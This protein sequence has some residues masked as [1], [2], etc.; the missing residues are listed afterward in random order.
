MKE[1]IKPARLQK[2]D[3]VAAISLSGGRAGDED[4]RWRYELGKKRLEEVFGLQVVETPHALRGSAYL[5]RNPQARAEDLHWALENRAVKG[6]IANMGGDDSYRLL[7]FLDERLIGENPKLLMGYSDITTTC[8][9][10][11]RAGV[12]SYYGPNLLTPIAQ[13]GSLD[14]YTRNAVE[15]ALFSGEVIGPVVPCQRH[16]PIEWRDL[17]ENQVVWTENEGYTLLQG[18]GKARGRLLGGSIGPLQQIMGT[19]Y[20][21]SREMW[22]GS[23]LFL[24]GA[25]PYGSTLAML[26][27]LRTLGAAGVFSQ[28]AG[29]LTGALRDE[30]QQV[31]TRFLRYEVGREDLPVLMN[32]DFCHRTPMAVLPVGAMAE[33]DCERRAF[34]ILESATV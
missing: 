4:L 14:P 16:T 19:E 32:V 25:S 15:R 9:T 29:L 24:D 22:A 11:A 17:P 33:I 23:I 20:F 10:Y 6:I 5:Y 18:C 7:P 30:E 31:L 34:A 28:A 1:W 13:P 21:P 12:M 3:M 8:M 26:H 2:G 27:S